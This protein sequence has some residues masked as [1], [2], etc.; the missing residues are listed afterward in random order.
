[1]SSF[2]DLFR[3]LLGLPLSEEVGSLGVPDQKCSDPRTEQLRQYCIRTYAEV[4][5]K[6]AESMIKRAFQLLVGD[7]GK[8]D[9]GI[10]SLGA[11]RLLLSKSKKEPTKDHFYRQTFV[12]KALFYN[13]SIFHDT[14]QFETIIK[15][16]QAV[17]KITKAEH[18]K[19]TG[20]QHPWTS[21]LY[22]DNDIKL[23]SHNKGVQGQEGY[24]H[25]W[26]K[27]TFAER[28]SDLTDLIIPEVLELMEKHV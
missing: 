19:I 18:D 23:F 26:K 28:S 24:I 17:I 13:P 6:E 11:K 20:E 12:G 27:V 1:M 4:E 9:V 2:T 7:M 5:S 25:A 8:T 14:A 21:R 16:S 3:A 10:V 15:A 22:Q